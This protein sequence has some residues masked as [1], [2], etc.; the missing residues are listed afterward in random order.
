MESLLW[1]ANSIF[2]ISTS[3]TSLKSPSFF[4]SFRGYVRFEALFGYCG[5]IRFIPLMCIFLLS[6][7]FPELL[8]TV[9][10]F[11]PL[12]FHSLECVCHMCDHRASNYH[13][14]GNYPANSFRVHSSCTEHHN[15]DSYF[16]SSLFHV[17][18]FIACPHSHRSCYST[19]L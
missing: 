14:C 7:C 6:T 5:Y 19:R 4:F 11:L 2:F 1:S 16:K 9:L 8:Y 17:L 18:S 12:S 10:G 15:C 13:S 3:N